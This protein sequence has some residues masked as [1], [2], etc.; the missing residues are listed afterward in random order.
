MLLTNLFISILFK[1]KNRVVIE[2]VFASYNESHSMN[3]FGLIMS[4]LQHFLYIFG[5]N[6]LVVQIL[7]EKY[8]W[9]KYQILD[10]CTIW[11]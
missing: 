7:F 4:F 5:V 2:F 8:K 11:F 10:N 6:V 1:T 3:D 9:T